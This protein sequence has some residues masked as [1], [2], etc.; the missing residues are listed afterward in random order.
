MSEN[1][2][3]IKPECLG[4]TGAVNL[5]SPSKSDLKLSENLEI[6]LKKMN[7]F[8]SQTD[9]E[10]RKESLYK[11]QNICNEWIYEKALENMYP[12]TIAKHIKGKLFAFGSY[13]LNS[14]FIGADIDTLLVCPK[15]ISR[16]ECFEEF[17]EFL[18][19]NSEAQEIQVISEAFVPL[20]TMK[21]CN[22]EMDLLFSVIDEST[23]SE[24]LNLQ[25]NT[26]QLMRTMDEKDI[27]SINGVRVTDDI[28]T[29][30]H[31][32]NV[33][34]LALRAIKLWAKRSGLYSNAMGFLGGVSWAI[35]VARVCQLWPT[36]SAFTI[37]LNFFNLYGNKWK[38]P[39]PIILKEIDYSNSL[40]ITQWDPKTEPKDS[41]HVMPIITPSYPC[42]NST[43]NVTQSHREIITNHMK[44]AHE[45]C[46]KI[47]NGNKKLSDLFEQK[48]FFIYQHYFM[49]TIN[50]TDKIEFD[51]NSNLLES[52]LRI[53][54][55]YLERNPLI[56]LVHVNVQ[57]YN[58]HVENSS[59]NIIQ[60][61]RHWFIGFE[62]NKKDKCLS[63]VNEITKFESIVQ[64]KIEIIHIKRSAIV[65]HLSN[66]DRVKFINF[67]P[68]KSMKRP[69]TIKEDNENKESKKRKLK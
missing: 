50:H 24:N 32:R 46:Q 49:V 16:N 22:I 33:F 28:L 58:C 6:T 12:K 13:R 5:L 31:N 37:I 52:R 14:D 38:W 42:Q 9:I 10:H 68:R 44:T 3:Q 56:E 8:M 1:R 39:V 40:S 35:L 66:E 51:K 29:L 20:I 30:V 65:Q 41:Y 53:F 45:L 54:A 43:Y 48:F 61:V 15:M 26:Q 23:V 17:Y 57:S 21:F 62:V 55:Q 34:R 64:I 25:N 36:A 59:K 18:S 11:L 60:F 7:V 19:K 2:E 63:V 4:I 47:S 67:L 69:N 27:R